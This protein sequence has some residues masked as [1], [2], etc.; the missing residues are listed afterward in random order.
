MNKKTST[1]K[2]PNGRKPRVVC[3]APKSDILKYKK[4]IVVDGDHK[5]MSFSGGQFCYCTS[6]Y[7]QDT[8]FPVK[9][10][11]FRKANELITRS[12]MYRKRNG[13]PLPGDK[14]LLMPVS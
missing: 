6:S 11:S 4:F 5:P 10:Y 8:H 7:W 9:T 2:K 14:Y 13:W 1:L 12:Q 3:R